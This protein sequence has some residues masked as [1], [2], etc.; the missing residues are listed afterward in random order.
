MVRKI[1]LLALMI[2]AFCFASYSQIGELKTNLAVGFNGGALYNTVDFS[3]TVSQEGY[4]GYLFGG[5]V[6]Y[7]S[8]KYMGMFCGLQMEAN[9]VDKGW[10]E[11]KEKGGFKRS[12]SYLEIPFFAHLAYGN[13]AVRG[14]LNIGPQFSFLLNERDIAG[15]NV[16]DAYN[17][18]HFA[19]KKFDYGIAGGLGMEVRSKAGNF[20]LEARYYFGLSD[21]YNNGKTDYY[22]RSA[23]STI[24][25][26]LTYLFDIIK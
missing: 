12:M 7:I 14:L 18:T 21:I 8:E 25:V 10:A 6:R 9:F 11:E 15:E 20:L 16:S 5:T 22:G 1:Y 4:F 23:H 26:K 19:D 3:P 2:F 13:R 24:S 17:H